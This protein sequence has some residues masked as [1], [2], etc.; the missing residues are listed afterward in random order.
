M[1]FGTIDA[2]LALQA[3]RPG[4]HRLLERVAH[5]A[6]RHRHAALGATSCATRSACRSRRFPKPAPSAAG[7]RRDR[8]GRLHRSARA[9]RRHGRRPAGGA[10]RAGLPASRASARTPTAPAASCCRTPGRSR[11]RC[12]T[13]LL[14]TVAWGIGDRVDYAL[15]ASVFVTGAAVQWLRD[16]LGIIREAAETEATGGVARLQRRRVLRAGADRP[17]LAALGPVRARHDRRPHARHG[18][19]AP[20]AR[21]ARGDR[22][23][24]GRRGARRWRRPRASRSAELRADGGAVANALADAVP[25]RRARPP[26]GRARRCRRRPRWA[27]P[28]WPG[29]GPGQ[30]TLD[31]VRSLWREAARYEPRM[32]EDERETAAGATGGGPSSGRGA[33]PLTALGL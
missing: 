4:G 28:T 11:R 1:R 14:T 27:R 6:V 26:G 21:G 18:P 25:G 2:W 10:V 13:G 24:D 8:P 32:G 29:S 3:H 31:D 7:A 19:R 9:G 22:L 5:D 12:A 30:W 15:E 17:R 20:R 23:P 16:G 33:G